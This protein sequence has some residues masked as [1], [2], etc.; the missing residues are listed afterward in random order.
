MCVCKGW[1]RVSGM[2]CE[3]HTQ[4]RCDDF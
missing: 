3:F 4:K 2:L 1:A